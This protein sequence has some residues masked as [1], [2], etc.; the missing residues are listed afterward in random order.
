[1]GFLEETFGARL[2]LN[3]HGGHLGNLW[4][5]EVQDKVMARLLECVP[6]K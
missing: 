3:D 6:I 5:P 2:E 1:V 4:R